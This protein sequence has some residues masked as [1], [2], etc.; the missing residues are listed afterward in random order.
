[1]FDIYIVNLTR[2][3]WRYLNRWIKLNT[4]TRACIA[5]SSRVTASRQAINRAFAS[6]T[7][8]S[9]T[10]GTPCTWQVRGGS[11]SVIGE[12]DTSSM[13]KRFPV[14]VKRKLKTTASGNDMPKSAVIAAIACANKMIDEITRT[15]HLGTSTTIITSWRTL[16]N[17]YMNSSLC[18]KSGSCLN[19]RFHLRISRNCLSYGLYSSGKAAFVFSFFFF[20]NT[21]GIREKAGPCAQINCYNV[22]DSLFI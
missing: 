15:F 11:S 16:G 17:L 6:R 9:G 12:H 2:E 18:K 19:S 1:M 20:R 7:T 21:Q 10:A 14:P 13:P 3:N 8:D 5:W 22:Y 4:A